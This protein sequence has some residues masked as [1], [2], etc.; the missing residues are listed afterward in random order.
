MAVMALFRSNRIA[1]IVQSVLIRIKINLG[2][3]SQKRFSD[4]FRK[5]C[6][7]KCEYGIVSLRDEFNL[8]KFIL[9]RLNVLV[10]ILSFKTE[11]FKFSRLFLRS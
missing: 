9:T 8:N 6:P 11:E 5:H 10:R 3:F 1:L 4:I 7:H 2:N